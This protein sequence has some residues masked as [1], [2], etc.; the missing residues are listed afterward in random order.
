MCI[1]VNSHEYMHVLDFEIEPTFFTILKAMLKLWLRRTR[2]LHYGD[3]TSKILSISSSW[4]IAMT[5]IV[6]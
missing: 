4:I 6:L 5:E 2:S 3:T 1:H